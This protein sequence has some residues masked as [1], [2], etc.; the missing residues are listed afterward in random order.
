MNSG[1]YVIEL[2]QRR[3]DKNLAKVTHWEARIKTAAHPDE[4]TN[5]INLKEQCEEDLAL[6]ILRTDQARKLYK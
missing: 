3:V 5:F 2:L 4:K 6:A 1:H